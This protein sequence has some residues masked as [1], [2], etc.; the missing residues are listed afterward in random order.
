MTTE[1]SQP[2]NSTNPQFVRTIQIDPEH[3]VVL[4][5]SVIESHAAPE[6]TT[7]QRPPAND[8]W[9]PLLRLAYG[10]ATLLTDEV[11]ERMVVPDD[12]LAS[13]S[14]ESVLIPQS[15][16]G[17]ITSPRP[18]TQARY[19]TVGALGDARRAASS[20][21]RA[22][23]E[24]TDAT[25]RVIGRVVG[26]VWNSFLLAPVRGPVRQW[27]L[28]GEQQV[29]EWIIEG[30]LEEARSR[31]IAEASLANLVQESVT[32]LTES[33]QI[34]VLVQDVI[35][36]QST[37]ILTQ[38]LEE[39]RERFI[40]VD[41]V[42][43]GTLGKTRA[44]RPEFRDHYL[45]AFAQRR[46]QYQHMQLARTMAGTYAGYVSRVV[47]FIIDVAILLLGLGLASAF[48]TNTLALFGALDIVQQFLYSGSL[49]ADISLVLLAVTNFLAVSGYGVLFWTLTGSTPGH[50]ILG[51]RVVDKNGDR[52]VF[53][54]SIRRI[55][56]AYVSGFALFLGFIWPLFDKRRQGW[57]DKIGSTFVV[58][59]WP[60]KPD[61]NFLND[62][63]QQELAEDRQ[64]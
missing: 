5:G 2:E 58:Y 54:Q 17:S 23:Y 7:S 62:R 64:S 19:M 4:E 10:S 39:T 48:V 31:A 8:S 50:A 22:A 14:P 46:P 63:V 26:P 42:L 27:R 30:R 53:W 52:L 13:R 36:S 44:P 32:D 37:S 15:E 60:A 18:L 11:G 12:V 43:S 41:M 28:R 59:D 9:P 55:I 3:A 57:H 1:S 29:N 21:L 6:E 51:L 38:L 49:M 25:G 61:E 16:W 56:G 20:G 24:F 33:P 45:D 40:S 34:Q 35:Q 47:A